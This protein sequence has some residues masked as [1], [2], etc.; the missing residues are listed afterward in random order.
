MNPF[1]N[2]RY[3][4]GV[5]DGVYKHGNYGWLGKIRANEITSTLLN[6]FRLRIDK[7]IALDVFHSHYLLDLSKKRQPSELLDAL[8]KPVEKDREL[9]YST[10]F[11]ELESKAFTVFYIKRVYEML[12]DASY[13]SD[14]G[15]SCDIANNLMNALSGNG[16][17]NVPDGF[18]SKLEDIARNAYE[19]AKRDTEQA[20]DNVKD[21]CS[22]A[23]K[24]RVELSLGEA[25]TLMEVTGFRDILELYRKI[26]SIP[27][28]K[29]KRDSSRGIVNGVTKGNKVQN[30]T[31]SSLL[32]PEEL[33]YYK[34]AT[35]QL[36]IRAKACEV[37]E[38]VYILI[39]ASGSMSGKKTIW[40]R[41]V[42]V[43]ILRSLYR[44]CRSVK[45]SFF[46]DGIVN[47]HDFKKDPKGTILDIVCTNSYG[48]TDIDDALIHAD[49][50]IDGLIICITD[51]EDDVS[52][53]PKNRLLSVMIDG[54]NDHLRSVSD[55]YMSVTP[56][57]KGGLK[58]VKI[59]S[60]SL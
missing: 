27:V 4:K 46:N 10:V 14:G 22:L 59:A 39:D 17:P 26:G 28:G 58:L 6:K 47:T 57:A 53:R 24:G 32:L 7:E 44:S 45:V 23:G 55:V 3:K 29:P 31:V 37:D 30:A 54:E 11:N 34:V 48:G 60:K 21:F 36:N 1:K 8:I 18:K 56:N 16:T 33:F 2:L 20:M 5:L 19:K 40:A 49:D 9:R 25:M 12:D 13:D 42:S 43:A 35:K 51:G 50:N 41:S 38:D 52:Y 15:D